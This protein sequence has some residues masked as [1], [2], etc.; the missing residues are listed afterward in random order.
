MATSE[1]HIQILGCFRKVTAVG[2]LPQ[3]STELIEGIEEHLRMATVD[4]QRIDV[5][6]CDW[7]RDFLGWLFLKQLK[8]NWDHQV[9]S[10]WKKAWKTENIVGT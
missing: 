10:R 6:F 7:F 3:G 5:R 1:K 8:L 9:R 4:I 2:L